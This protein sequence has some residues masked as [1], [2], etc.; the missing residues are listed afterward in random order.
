MIALRRRLAAGLGMSE[1]AFGRQL[2]VSYAKV[3]EFQKR[4]IV[5]FHAIIRLDGAGDGYPPSPIAVPD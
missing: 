3:D 1:A 2:R 5:H 4:G